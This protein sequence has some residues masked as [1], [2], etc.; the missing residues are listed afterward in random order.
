MSRDGIASA[1]SAFTKQDSSTEVFSE[2]QLSTDLAQFLSN[3]TLRA[4]LADGSLDLTSYS[5]T[6][7]GELAELEIQCI[8]AYRSKTQEIA[9]LCKD[10]DHCDGVLLGVQEML[11]GFQA[12]LGGLSGDIRQL[13]ET[14]KRLGIQLHNR[15]AAAIGMREF[16]GRIVLSPR[17]CET[18]TKGA[19]NLQFQQAIKE[20]SR[21][22]NDTHC[23]SPQ[24]W[25]CKKPPAETSAGEEMQEHIKQLR[26]VAVSRIR[27]YFFQQ[28]VLLR[29][30]QTNI[31]ILQSHGLLH[32]ADLYEF[33]LDA[34]PSVAQELFKAYTTRMSNTMYA[35]FRTYQAQLIQLD[36][37]KHAATRQDVLAVEDAYLRDSITTKAKKR[38]DVFT[39]GSRANVLNTTHEPPV[40]AHVALSEQRTYPY[41]RLLKSCLQHLV[42]AVTNEHV[43]CRQFFKRDAFDSLFPNSLQLLLEQL[44]NYLFGCYDALCILLMIK[45]IHQFRKS[46][47]SRTIHSLDNFFDQMTNLLWPRLKTVMEIH[48][49]SI[50][51]AT[52]TSLGGVDLHAHY[53]S[54]R[55]AEFT[56]SV[57][58][59]LQKGNK[60]VQ[61][62]DRN[63][64]SSLKRSNSQASQNREKMNS[65]G[66]IASA[67][68]MLLRDLNDLLGD[69][70]ALLKRLAEEHTVNIK[71]IVFMIN[72]LDQ[73]VCIFQERRVAGG[74]E[75]NRVLELLM[76]QRELFVEEELLQ[77]FSKM[78]AFVQQTETS[79]AAGAVNDK[80]VNYQVVESLVREF[81]SNWRTGMEAINRN[82]LSY[83]SNFRNGME[84]LKQV[85]TQLLLYYTRFQDV[86]RKVFKKQQ[87]DFAK[88]LVPTAVILAEIK[89]YA[90]SI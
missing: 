54:R 7:E 76:L 53:V 2:E 8:F 34:S 58:L 41:E 23:E 42:D 56:C 68:E 13:Q 49:R 59:I 39:L 78:I 21:L 18:I 67:G 26:L 90:L 40:V 19:I 66:S 4:A 44:E 12:D 73:V 70:I 63:S 1:L 27:E 69:Y 84:I 16:L 62:T 57:L 11:L 46:A 83:F 79:L 47:Q 48:Q 32:H 25:A 29:K 55:F 89:K 60:Q 72:N 6:V 77:G 74:K 37:T 86:V 10:L 43:V 31:R 9:R 65:I 28:M 14:S 5:S 52:A 17:L 71:K 38:V 81:A 15:K 51:Q 22:Y 3:P 50:K 64:K 33:L 20:L 88:D 30:P 80:S 82:V 75:L 61:S 87:P 24:D 36:A 45:V 35:L 85:L